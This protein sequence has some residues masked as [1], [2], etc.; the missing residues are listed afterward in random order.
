[1][2]FIAAAAMKAAVRLIFLSLCFLSLTE[3]QAQDVIELKNGQKIESKVVEV[4]KK[5]IVY[6][7]F[8]NP[9]GPGF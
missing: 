7:K 4:L 9:S 6:R 8:S 3:M 2:S 1:M 5:V